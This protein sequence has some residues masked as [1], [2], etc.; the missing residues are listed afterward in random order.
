MFGYLNVNLWIVGVKM[1]PECFLFSQNKVL[2]A[3]LV[4]SSAHSNSIEFLTT[5]ENDLQIALMLRDFNSPVLAHQHLVVNRTVRSTQEFIWIRE[6]SARILI[7]ND[8]HTISHELTLTT[9]DSILF[10]SGGHAID[11][12]TATQILEVKQGPYQ[13]SHDKIFLKT[14]L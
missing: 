8:D 14:E 10:V 12:L 9:G 11:F 5:P 3:I 13:P 2:Q 7:F 1:N 6:G 4:P